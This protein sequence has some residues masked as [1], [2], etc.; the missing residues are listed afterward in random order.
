[1]DVEVHFAIGVDFVDVK[2]D[3]VNMDVW[4]EEFIMLAELGE[5]AIV[6]VEHIIPKKIRSKTSK[7][8]FGDWENYLPGNVH[9]EH[10]KRI[11]RIGNM[12]LF[13]GKLNIKV[14]N[15][16]FLDKRREYQNS[17][18]QLTKSLSHY[19]YFKFDHLDNRGKELAEIAVK[20][21]RL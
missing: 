16:P 3:V 12:T 14:S 8:E 10:K 13:S 20:I 19:K 2:I 4:T 7:K 11:N 18:I 9:L 5:G 1:M 17:N 15:G 6:Y 21:W